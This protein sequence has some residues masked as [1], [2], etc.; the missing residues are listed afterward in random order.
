[1][2][3]ILRTLALAGTVAAAG[4]AAQAQVAF[5]VRVAPPVAPV[6]YANYVPACPGVGY[7]WTPGYYAGAAWV[8]GRWIHHDEYFVAHRDYRFDRDHG[9]RGWDHG[10]R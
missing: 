10:R 7:A 8:P 9:Y 2:K 3:G 6:L 1:M 4:A 5:A